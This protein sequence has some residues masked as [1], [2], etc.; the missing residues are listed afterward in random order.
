MENAVTYNLN[1]WS[2]YE[3][4]LKNNG[5]SYEQVSRMLV[6]TGLLGKQEEKSLLA[7]DN[8]AQQA[9]AILDQLTCSPNYQYFW[10]TEDVYEGNKCGSVFAEMLAFAAPDW[11]V[12]WLEDNARG[13]ESI[14]LNP[15]PEWGGEVATTP[16]MIQTG[17]QVYT[18]N[19]FSANSKHAYKAIAEELAYWVNALL[20]REECATRL[21]V[22]CPE[23]EGEN[24]VQ[25][26]KAGK[27]QQQKMDVAFPLSL[28]QFDLDAFKPV[29]IAA[30]LADIR[31]IYDTWVAQGS[32]P[33][34]AG[35]S[36][37]LLKTHFNISREAFAWLRDAREDMHEIML[38]DSNE[39]PEAFAPLRGLSGLER[40]REIH[41]LFVA[42]ARQFIF[43]QDAFAYRYKLCPLF[44]SEQMQLLRGRYASDEQMIEAL[45]SD[46]NLYAQTSHG[47]E[48]YLHKLLPAGLA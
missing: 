23:D 1:S 40:I 4:Y 6:E 13:K 8:D 29:D 43:D 41:N 21:Y 35:S 14:Q 39:L 3:T 17:N 27:D 42:V 28:P 12:G 5:I 19:I 34:L 26:I 2:D 33:K 7:A 32:Y 37:P 38:A 20:E 16:I 10:L 48:P 44:T 45:L 9:E 30:Q 36:V 24:V 31:T 15:L 18:V 25:F 11:Q 46:E 47:A 22:F